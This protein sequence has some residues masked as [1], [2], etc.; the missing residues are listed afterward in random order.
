MDI[1]YLYRFIPLLLFAHPFHLALKNRNKV[2]SFIC[3][4]YFFSAVGSLFVSEEYLMWHDFE[5]DTFMGFFLYSLFNLPLLYISLLVRPFNDLSR[6]NLDSFT[7]LFL[8]FIGLGAI[9]SLI[10]QL[11]YALQALSYSAY[12]VRH[13]EESLLP[14]SGFTTI[15]VGFPM[16]LFIYVFYF[17]LSIVKRWPL[18]IKI[19]ML[20]GAVNFVVNV[21]TVSGRDG[22]V[23]F[24]FAFI[25][26]YFLFEP[27]FNKTTKS[28]IRIIA[29][30]FFVIFLVLGTIITLDRFSISRNEDAN[31]AF[32]VG[33]LNYFSMQPFTYNDILLYHQDFSY[34]KGNFPLFYSWFFELKDTTRDVSMPYMYNF[35]GY[36]GSFHKNGGYVYFFI[37]ASLFYLLFR[38]IRNAHRHYYFFSFSLLS[39]YFF[40]MTSG[41][42]YFR[43]GN[44]GG[45]LFIFLSLI[46]MLLFHKR[47]S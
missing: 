16:F 33:V 1:L 21:L 40:F 27:H 10:Y 3:A 36:V 9:Y 4:L 11:P 45:N 12:E 30:S 43:L 35:A 19:L 8:L 24:A 7:K 39:L 22:F 6:F 29:L 38:S 44:K 34:G 20:I 18:I 31:F 32:Q 17:Y 47:R 15:A 14:S 26:G 13:F 46:L 37:V 5:T 41:L 42:F 25:L 2:A 28:R 23:F